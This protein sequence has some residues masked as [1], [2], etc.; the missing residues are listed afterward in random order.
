MFLRNYDNFLLA[1]MGATA[2][3]KNV[4]TA[5]HQAVSNAGD[6]WYGTSAAFGTNSN[7]GDGYINVRTMT[8]SISKI[9]LS[10]SSGSST[11]S[12]A[13]PTAI[14][15]ANIVLGTGVDEVTYE[16][17]KLSGDSISTDPLMFHSQNLT[18]GDVTK[19]FTRS[20]TFTYTN[21]TDS[22]VTIREWGLA[23][24]NKTVLVFREVL[25]EPITIAAGTTGTL[26]FSIELPM[27][28]HP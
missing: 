26:T 24:C 25:T 23:M 13:C 17:Y 20:V 21:T 16:D 9:A 18:W 19:K 14:T 10:Y 5:S 2:Q 4:A 15:C 6:L 22:D 27:F 12:I 1:V 28:N 8:N 7:H 3:G 11:L